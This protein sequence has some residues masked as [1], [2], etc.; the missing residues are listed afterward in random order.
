VAAMIAWESEM[1][2]GLRDLKTV[3][4]KLRELWKGGWR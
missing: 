4:R 1:M 2:A 3:L